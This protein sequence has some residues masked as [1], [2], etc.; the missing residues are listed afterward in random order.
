MKNLLILSLV[1]GLGSAQLFGQE[2][3]EQELHRLAFGAAQ[4]MVQE[5]PDL[6]PLVEVNTEL[7]KASYIDFVI[8]KNPNPV[9]GFANAYVYGFRFRTPEFERMRL[10]WS[11]SPVPE[12]VLSWGIR[13]V[14]SFSATPGFTHW[15]AF[16]VKAERGFMGAEKGEKVWFQELYARAPGLKNNRPT[17]ELQQLEP[18]KEYFIVF[19]MSGDALDDEQTTGLSLNIFSEFHSVIHMMFRG[20]S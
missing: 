15:H 4:S 16:K 3:A 9:K 20:G 19:L 7:G 6:L 1:L 10:V 17:N 13:P 12:G 2:A 5:N 11:F 8:P 14:D 18:G